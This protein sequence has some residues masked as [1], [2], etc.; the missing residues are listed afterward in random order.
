MTF[1][2][3]RT[4]FPR[5]GAAGRRT[6]AL[7][8]LAARSSMWSGLRHGTDDMGLFTPPGVVA[9]VVVVVVGSQAGQD[10]VAG[11][12]QDVM[13]FAGQFAGH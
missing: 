5:L 2:G 12:T 6:A 1:F 8:V 4:P 13:R 3:G 9:A 10:V 11:V 7:L